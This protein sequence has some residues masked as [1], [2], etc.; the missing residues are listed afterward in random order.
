MSRFRLLESGLCFDIYEDVTDAPNAVQNCDLRF[1]GT[2]K[3]LY[4]RIVV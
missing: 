3:L 4:Q 1:G 2:K